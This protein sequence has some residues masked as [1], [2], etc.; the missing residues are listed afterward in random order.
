M[1]H[2]IKEVIGVKEKSVRAFSMRIGFPYT[3]LNNYIN[4]VRKTIDAELLSKITS[5]YVDISAEWLLTGRGGMYV[6]GGTRFIQNGVI[7]G[8]EIK[9]RISGIHRWL[10]GFSRDKNVYDIDETTINVREK[11]HNIFKN[12]IHSLADDY[13]TIIVDEPITESVFLRNSLIYYI[14]VMHK[15]LFNN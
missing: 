7:D 8:E 2:R 6:G 3:T 13:Q 9:G 12:K 5:T 15:N 1:I 4:G 11:T 14:N 10:D